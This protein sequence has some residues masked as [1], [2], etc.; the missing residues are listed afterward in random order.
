MSNKRV[1]VLLKML[2]DNTVSCICNDAYDLLYT[3][4][5]NLSKKQ[6]NRIRRHIFKHY[7]MKNIISLCDKANPLFKRKRALMQ[8]GGNFV[9]WLKDTVDKIN[10][11]LQKA[12]IGD[13]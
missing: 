8:E 9:G 2:D 4:K 1:K 12:V 5:F 3:N 6:K 11:F 7:R 10:I 13:Y